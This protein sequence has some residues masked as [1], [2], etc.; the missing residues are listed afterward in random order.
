LFY[1]ISV[2]LR[3]SLHRLTLIRSW[4]PGIKHMVQEFRLVRT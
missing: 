1:S 4:L 3:N 2:G